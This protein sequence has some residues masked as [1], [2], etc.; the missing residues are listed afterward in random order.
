MSYT[1]A[2]IFV[3][4]TLMMSCATSPPV[5]SYYVGGGNL[6]FFVRASEFKNSVGSRLSA[7]FSYRKISVEDS[8]VVVNASWY[9]SSIDSPIEV[10]VE[11]IFFAPGGNE[12]RL[13]NLEPLF[14]PA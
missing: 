13:H 8:T 9:S 14:R 1:K 7:D 2:S 11:M 12:I 6:Q 10:P 4:F 5:T 3:L